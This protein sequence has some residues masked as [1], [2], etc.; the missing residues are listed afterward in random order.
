M[1]RHLAESLN[2][3]VT[4]EYETVLLHFKNT[5]G[6]E[7]VCIGDFYG[8]P[9]CAIISKDEKYVVIAGCGIIIYR[10]QEPFEEYATNDRTK[11]HFEF[12]RE[13]D[14]IWWVDNLHQTDSDQDWK[15]FRF[16]A[17]ISGAN[18]SYRMDS[19]TFDLEEMHL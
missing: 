11:Q 17:E 4:C 18:F 5:S 2:Y 3:K 16:N 1:Q 13:P 19:R 10:L 7:P 12:F 9:D 8:D 6:S 14:K 15:Y